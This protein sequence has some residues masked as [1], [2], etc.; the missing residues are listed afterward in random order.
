MFFKRS[1]TAL[2]CIDLCL[3]LH[4]LRITSGVQINYCLKGYKKMGIFQV[5]SRSWCQTLFLPFCRMLHA[6]DI[7]IANFN[8]R[9][10]FAS[11]TWLVPKVLDKEL[12]KLALK[13][14]FSKSKNVIFVSTISKLVQNYLNLSSLWFWRTSFCSGFIPNQHWSFAMAV[15]TIQWQIWRLLSGTSLISCIILQGM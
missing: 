5:T 4:T 11:L 7:E 1:G 8:W 10:K 9:L 6:H 2:S 3:G 12:C 14:F 15:F 13:K